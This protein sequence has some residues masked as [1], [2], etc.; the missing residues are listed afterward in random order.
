V[1]QADA[2]LVLLVRVLDC[3]GF[4]GVRLTIAAFLAE[5]GCMSEADLLAGGQELVRDVRGRVAKVVGGVLVVAERS[6][7]LAW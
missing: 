1:S 5:G 2:P 6:V 3:V 7:R 4:C